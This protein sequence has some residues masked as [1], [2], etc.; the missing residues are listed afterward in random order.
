MTKRNEGREFGVGA[1]GL[2]TEKDFSK[3]LGTRGTYSGSELHWIAGR[4][5][6]GELLD[7]LPPLITLNARRQGR[8]VHPT[9]RTRCDGD[10]RGE[11]SPGPGHAQTGM[12]VDR[13]LNTT[14]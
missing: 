13:L 1:W 4:P 12:A 14:G 5:V 6:K 10:C 9:T 11:E 7:I 3:K 8:K 2:R